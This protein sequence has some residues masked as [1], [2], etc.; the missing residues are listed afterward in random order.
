M[1][2][3]K[4]ARCERVSTNVHFGGLSRGV[5]RLH[6]RNTACHGWVSDEAYSWAS[7][8]PQQVSGAFFELTCRL[9]R[10]SG[11]EIEISKPQEKTVRGSKNAA[12]PRP[13][14]SRPLLV[15]PTVVNAAAQAAGRFR[16]D[17]VV[18][19]TRW[20][21]NILFASA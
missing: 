18:A 6:D 8:G 13:P 15:A 14:L 20:P 9:P 10:L 11:Q 16:T 1:W 5:L 7:S 3:I 21:K 19:R 12:P 4:E 17:V 2:S